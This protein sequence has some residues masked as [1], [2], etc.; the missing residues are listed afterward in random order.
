VLGKEGIEEEGTHK[1]LLAKHGTYYR[2][3]NGI[4]PGESIS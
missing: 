4:L 3:W 2:L 1:Q